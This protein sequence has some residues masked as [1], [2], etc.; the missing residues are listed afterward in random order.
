MPENLLANHTTPRVG[1]PATTWII[2]STEDQLITAI[3]D[4]DTAK[5]PLVVLA[6]ARNMVVADDGVPG[7][8]V[9]IAT[10]G[11]E[12]LESAR[13]DVQIKMAVGQH[14]D[15]VVEWSVGQGLSGI[16]ALS[17]IPGSTG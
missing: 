12:V 7:T 2:A 15:A 13:A 17:G 1:G 11:I 8:V 4:T 14:W 5:P 16:D 10:N 6:G 9:R 3:A